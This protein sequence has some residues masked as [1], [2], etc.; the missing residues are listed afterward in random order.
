MNLKLPEHFNHLLKL[1]QQ[2]ETNL[3]LHRNRHDVWTASLETMSA[4]IEES[5]KRNFKES[6][7]QQFLTIAP[8]FFI[9]KW[10]MRRGRLQM[11]V[12]FPADMLD[13]VNNEKLAKEKK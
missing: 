8:G 7:F 4:M 10:E 12:E 11:C 2:F 3:R 13:Q 9:H 1:F 5:Y 6:H